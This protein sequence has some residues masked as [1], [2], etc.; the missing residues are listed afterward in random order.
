MNKLLLW[1][2]GVFIPIF[3]LEFYSFAQSKTDDSWKIFDDSLVARVDINVSETAIAYMYQNVQSDSLHY[4]TVRFRNRYIDET[5][6]SV[7]ISLRGNTS[8]N[9]A[10]KSFKLAFNYFIPG[11]NFHN[12]DKMNLNGEHNDPSI[13]R[14]KLCWDLFNDVGLIHS[15]AAHTEVYINGKYYGLYINV[16][17]VDDKYLRKNFND[18]SGNLWKCLYPA[19]LVYLGDDQSLYKKIVGGIKTYDLKTNE[20][21]DDYSKLVRLIS[22]INKTSISLLPDSIEKAL[23]VS[24]A[25]KFFAFNT[26]VSSWDDYRSL[27]NN[28]YLYHEP[29]KD[30]FTILPYDYDNTFAVDWFQVDWANADPYNY[31]KAVQGSRPLWDRLISIKQYRNLYT[32]FLEF[33]NNK[34]FK[35]SLWDDRLENLRIKITSS[36]LSDS[37]RTID[38][39]FTFSDFLNS[40]SSAHYENQH[41]KRGLREYVNVRSN[42]LMTK[43]NY[44]SGEKS[45]VYEYDWYPKNPGPNDTIYITASAFSQ[46]G[47]SAVGID[48]KDNNGV[49]TTYFPMTYS[50]VLNTKKVEEADKWK[51]A[52]PPLG[53]NGSGKFRITAKDINMLQMSFPRG[54]WINIK[55]APIENDHVVINELLAKNTSTNTDSSGQYEDWIELYNPTIQ[56]ISLDGYYLSDSPD[57][58]MRWQFPSGVSIAP[59]RY[60]LI[61][62]DNDL[63]QAGLHANFKLSADGEFIALTSPDGI[64]IIDSVS[65]GTQNADISFG[66]LPDAGLTWAFLMP[67]PGMKNLI[68]SVEDELLVPQTFRVAVFPNPFNSTSTLRFTL[69]TVGKVKIAYYDI[70]GRKIYSQEKEYNS[71]GTYEFKWNGKDDYGNEVSSGIYFCTI[72]AGKN[73]E[74]L[75]LVLMK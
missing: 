36:V 43:L 48:Y 20:A 38:Y 6:D 16:E 15:R 32:H 50:P 4:C 10:K 19:D 70:L 61:W 59:L 11:R 23:D 46:A 8:R 29:A 62:C 51:A 26:L 17:Q 71:T 5:L 22:I 54:E 13:I 52:I 18:A 56:S 2:V 24:G 69:P 75:K 21:G 35:L 57:S 45:I 39:Q 42:S 63:D 65:F 66:R 40:Y 31:P 73:F 41:V 7:G 28:Y 58:L 12:I 30:K 49:S 67:T 74:T 68:T 14:S 64:T 55:T 37:F 25:F 1:L 47:L 27:N 44:F 9:S 72:E 53:V 34:V 3:F 33:Y 60:F